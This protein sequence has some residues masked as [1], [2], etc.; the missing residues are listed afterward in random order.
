MWCLRLPNRSDIKDYSP[1]PGIEEL[2]AGTGRL[3]ATVD[4]TAAYTSWK[5]LCLTL[6][7]IVTLEARKAGVTRPFINTQLYKSDS[8]TNPGDHGEH[9]LTGLAVKSFAQR[10]PR[11][12]W[13]GYCIGDH[14]GESDW[15]IDDAAMYLGKF[16]LW[17]SYNDAINAGMSEA[18][19]TFTECARRWFDENLI[20]REWE[21]WGA[22]SH[23]RI[24]N[25]GDTD[26]YPI[27][28]RP[29]SD[30]HAGGLSVASDVRHGQD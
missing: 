15:T 1:L 30:V 2:Y 8:G 18:G 16:R 20:Q 19:N 14:Q 21:R 27:A 10:F 4:R 11:A 22:F 6:E 24:V 12:W 3:V 23:A 26:P 25:G 7:Q 9:T 13:Y 29:V 28:P 17:K 5:D